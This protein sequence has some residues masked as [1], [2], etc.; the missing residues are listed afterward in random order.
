[1]SSYRLP[2]AS[3]WKSFALEHSRSTPCTE[4]VWDTH[5]G[6]ISLTPTREG[7]ETQYH[8]HP[9]GCHRFTEPHTC[10]FLLSCCSFSSC[11]CSF[12]LSCSSSRTLFCS[13][14]KTVM[15]IAAFSTPISCKGRGVHR[16]WFPQHKCFREHSM[17]CCPPLYQPPVSL[18]LPNT[19]FASNTKPVPNH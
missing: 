11:T 1:M 18:L 2:T 7:S 9:T 8:Q 13:F 12:F 5:R 14:R 17:P 15:S 19:N 10:T 4:A 3:Q 16:R 6:V